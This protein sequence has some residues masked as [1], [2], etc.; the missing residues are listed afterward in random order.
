MPKSLRQCSTIEESPHWHR[1]AIVE[2][3]ERS[4]I[5]ESDE[6]YKEELTK[7]EERTEK[8]ELTEYEEELRAN[9]A[10]S[11]RLHGVGSQ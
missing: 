3:I 7:E 9:L 2:R 5:S 6:K 4:G 1:K 8:E 11:E 10:S